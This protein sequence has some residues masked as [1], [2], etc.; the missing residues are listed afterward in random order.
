MNELGIMPGFDRD[1]T[2]ALPERQESLMDL[3]LWGGAN[4]SKTAGEYIFES[5]SA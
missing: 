3:D 1:S 4:Q 5:S 2:I